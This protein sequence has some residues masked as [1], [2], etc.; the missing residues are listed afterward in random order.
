MC[1]LSC[2]IIQKASVSHG[3]LWQRLTSVPLLCTFAQNVKF[4][5]FIIKYIWK[6]YTGCW[7]HC[8]PCTLLWLSCCWVVD[9]FDTKIW[10]IIFHLWLT[11][12]DLRVIF[13]TRCYASTVY[14][15]VVYP[16]V[17]PSVRPSHASIVPKQLNLGS[18]KQRQRF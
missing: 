1:Y 14:A 18:R 5:I 11:I 3:K 12:L 13:T 9:P 7:T 8:T 15:V 17:R 16:S 10:Y 6:T 2:M 4:G